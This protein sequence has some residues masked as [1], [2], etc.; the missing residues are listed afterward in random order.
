[1]RYLAV[2]LLGACVLLSTLASPAPAPA[3]A[4]PAPEEPSLTDE[5][6]EEIRAF[7]R[8]WQEA[9][10]DMDV[11]RVM[12]FYTDD[13]L[14]SGMDRSLHR[15]AYRAQFSA[16][17]AREGRLSMV[18]E[19]R[20]IRLWQ[21]EGPEPA[22]LADVELV[23]RRVE[24][25]DGERY[26]DR[27]SFP[28]RLRRENGEWKAC[29]DG[30][31]TLC[32]VQVG[33]HDERYMLTFIA[34]SA[35]PLF[36]SRA[37]VKGPGVPKME[38]MKKRRDILGKPYV[39]DSVFLAQ[40]PEIGGAYTFSIPYPDDTEFITRPVRSVVDVAPPI[41]TPAWDADVHEWPLKISWK[42]VS[43][44]IKDF[45]AYEVHVRRAE[46][47]S[48]LY[49]FRSRAA[50]CTEVMLGQTAEQRGRFTEP[51]QPYYAEVYAYDAYG[52]YALSRCRFYYMIGAD[53]HIEQE[54]DQP[55]PAPPEPL[56]P[57]ELPLEQ[58][59]Q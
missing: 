48:R 4:Q 26:E 25:W 36:G 53:E 22:E 15:L 35:F 13:F 56:Q 19:L 41:V 29:G 37:Q 21:V 9:V 38:L 28:I 14:Q 27:L 16:V 23:V 10:E 40:R 43:G 17:R 46:D 44:Q 55:A 34:E 52:N 20:G 2:V 57:P 5:R 18:P 45:S 3:L 7:F 31:R 30:S 58:P 50:D 32:V 51:H 8:G 33:Y 12:S 42:D 59:A 39:T 1:M 6:E 24:S 11:G 47:N 54:G 49:V